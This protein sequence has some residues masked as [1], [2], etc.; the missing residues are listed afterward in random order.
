MIHQ[1]SQ[2]EAMKLRGIG[3]CEQESRRDAMHVESYE[4]TESRIQANGKIP[5]E[6]GVERAE[7][8]CPEVGI[9]VLLSY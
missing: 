5:E 7:E 4:L 1:L 6:L 8:A 3:E 2:C 9:E